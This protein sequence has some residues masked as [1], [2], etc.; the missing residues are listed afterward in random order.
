MSVKLV[1]D[2]E[3]LIAADSLLKMMQKVGDEGPAAHDRP[4]TPT[5][6]APSGAGAVSRYSTE[7]SP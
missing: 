2:G 1:P 3:T 7:A 5:E 4:S 6:W